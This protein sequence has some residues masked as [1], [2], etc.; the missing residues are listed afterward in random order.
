MSV[1]RMNMAAQYGMKVTPHA[2]LLE[3]PLKPSKQFSV[4]T[5]SDSYREF[6]SVKE[7]RK[8]LIQQNFIRKNSGREKMPS[9]TSLL[10]DAM[11]SYCMLSSSNF[12]PLA[13]MKQRKEMKPRTGCRVQISAQGSRRKWGLR[14]RKWL[15]R[16]D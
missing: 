13:L 4:A 10:V 14:Q 6:K 16:H 9:Q 7:E 12:H 3:C 5:L 2:K 8:L 1:F 15:G 11:C